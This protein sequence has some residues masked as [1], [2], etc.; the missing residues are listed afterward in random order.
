MGCLATLVLA[1]SEVSYLA[2]METPEVNFILKNEIISEFKSIR[3]IM[4]TTTLK[5]PGS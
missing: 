4:F 1:P 3:E 5:Y 2:E